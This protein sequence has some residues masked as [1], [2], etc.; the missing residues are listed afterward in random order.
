MKCKPSTDW[1]LRQSLKIPRTIYDPAG[2]PPA[3]GAGGG[4]VPKTR[5]RAGAGAGAE[6]REV[7]TE[8]SCS[9][10]G[11][12]VHNCNPSMDTAYSTTAMQCESKNLVF[13]LV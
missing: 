5:S 12:Y 11:G 3:S 2:W 10:S 6:G 13:N 1:D 9:E 4:G 8:S 7:H